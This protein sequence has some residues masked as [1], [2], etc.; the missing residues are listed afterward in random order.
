VVTWTSEKQEVLPSKC[1]LRENDRIRNQNNRGEAQAE[2]SGELKLDDTR[3]QAGPTRLS[4]S[5]F[6]RETL[7]LPYGWSLSRRKCKL[8]PSTRFGESMTTTKIRVTTPVE[9]REPQVWHFD[10]MTGNPAEAIRWAKAAPQ[11]LPHATVEVVP[12]VAA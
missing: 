11:V 9:G 8:V 12:Q 2:N 6:E 10:L 3:L 5:S 7:A 1:R 4:L